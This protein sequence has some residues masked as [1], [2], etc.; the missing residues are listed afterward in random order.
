MCASETRINTFQYCQI[1]TL[2]HTQ[3]RFLKS[4]VLSYPVRARAICSFELNTSNLLKLTKTDRI[5]THTPNSY[6]VVIRMSF[7]F[8]EEA[9]FR[10]I[11][12]SEE[13]NWNQLKFVT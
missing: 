3:Y 13:N 10:S 1:F 12:I 11:A 7:F 6:F 8:R 5:H 9:I 4:I 2:T